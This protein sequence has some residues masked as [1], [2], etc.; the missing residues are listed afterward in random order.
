MNT[1][2]CDFVKKYAKQKSTRLHMPG[3][4]GKGFFGVEKF[5]ITEI[6][7]ADVLYSA[8]GIILESEKN[9]G[10]LFNT[11]KTFY[12]TEGSSLSIRAMLYLTKLYLTQ[13]GQNITILAGRNAHKTFVTAAALLNI[14]VKWLYSKENTDLLSCNITAKD[15]EEYLQKSKVG[16]VYLTTPDYLGNI[17]N[18]KEIAKVCKKYKVLLIVDNAH[19]AYLNFLQNSLHPIYLGADMCC[20][21]AHKTLPVLTGGGYLHISKK[22]PKEFVNNAES[23]MSIF[24][25]TS[26]S[27]LILQSLDMANSYLYNGYKEKLN[28]F[29]EKV[30]A[31][32]QT[33]INNGINLVGDEPLKITISTKQMGYFGNELKDILLSFNIVAEYYDNDYLVLMLSLENDKDLKKIEKALLQIPK[34]EAINILPPKMVK[35]KKVCS[36]NKALFSD[37]EELPLSKAAGRVLAAPTVSCPPAIP[38]AVCGE[39]ITKEVI[40]IAKYYNIKTLKV[41]KK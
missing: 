6:D 40:E 27:Y 20:D 14:N 13:N 37:S 17:L 1:P 33:L 31:L 12:S 21:S 24:A 29:I 26:P 15:I 39:E 22:A 2:I 16:A 8:N 4:K 23:A 11:A 9:A 32:K 35:P 3:H 18:I 41:I 19:G 7:S 5:D 36:L 10:K 38:V 28:C 25:T 34:K 30:N